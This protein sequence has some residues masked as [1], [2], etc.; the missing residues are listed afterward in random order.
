MYL[1]CRVFWFQVYIQIIFTKICKKWTFQNYWIG[2]NKKQSVNYREGSFFAWIV[3]KVLNK[4]N[5]SKSAISKNLKTHIALFS[6]VH[7]SF[8]SSKSLQF[9]FALIL[10]LI[11]PFPRSSLSF[12]SKIKNY[13]IIPRQR[14]FDQS[15]LRRFQWAW[16]LTVDETRL[17]QKWFFIIYYLFLFIPLAF[18]VHLGIPKV[19]FY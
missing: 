7:L 5:I 2:L 8:R 15:E 17:F 12:L 4:K 10:I 13:P 9:P 6:L 11:L 14:I 3:L 16:R 1:F 18:N 19:N